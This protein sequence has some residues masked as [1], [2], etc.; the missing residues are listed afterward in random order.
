MISIG[1]WNVFLAPTMFNR[2]NRE[3]IIKENITKY[4]KNNDVLLF[5]ELHSWKIGPISYLLY[6]IRLLNYFPY[7]IDQ[8]LC[9]GNIGYFIAET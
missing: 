9:D 8:F 5:Q 7:L 1:T 6:K 3:H 4:M 2:F